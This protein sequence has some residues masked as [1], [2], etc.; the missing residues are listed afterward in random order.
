MIVYVVTCND[1]PEAVFASEEDADEFI[2]AKRASSA[3]WARKIYWR[4]AFELTESRACPGASVVL[5]SGETRDDVWLAIR[6]SPWEGIRFSE[7]V[8]CADGTWAAIGRDYN[9]LDEGT[10]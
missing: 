5:L 4:H 9:G 2:A 1:Y 8:Q 10:T 6:R 3:P 7:P